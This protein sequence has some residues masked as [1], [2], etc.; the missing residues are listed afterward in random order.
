MSID[1]RP[2]ALEDLATVLE[3][4]QVSLGSPQL[5]ERIE[6]LKTISEFTLRL[7]AFDGQ[8]AVGSTGTYSF[9][10]TVPGERQVQTAGVTMVGVLPTH[11]RRGILRALLRRQLE[12]AHEQGQPLAALFSSEG[13]IY[14]R[15][16]FGMASLSA[17]VDIA[18][19]HTAFENDAPKAIA[20]ARLVDKDAAAAIFPAIWDRVR[21]ATPGMLSRSEAWWRVR[22]VGDPP[23]ARGGHSLLQ[24]VLIEL[25]GRAAAYAIYR[26]LDSGWDSDN[27]PTM[28]VE[29]VEAVGDDSAATAAVWRYLYGIDLVRTI[30]ARLLPIDHPLLFLLADARRLRMHV[31]D[32]LWVR[33]VD[34]HAALSGRGYAAGPPLVFLVQ[35]SLC[36]WN[37]GSWQLQNGVAERTN[38]SPDLSLSIDALSSAY[39][40]AFRFSQLAVAGRVTELR[41]GALLAAD[42]MFLAQQAPWSPE[43]F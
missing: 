27:L 15:F 37:E 13:A 8:Q 43:V 21:S 33:L 3:P 39:L 10:M 38:Q 42:A 36:P 14:R 30:K 7:G 29:V 12:I 2:V 26:L 18:R 11:R 35:D 24:R 4:A 5:P 19:E 25:D 17:E 6:Q 32:G 28:R 41:K 16:G 40:G 9:S 20:S 1:I 31:Y 34:V 22:R 23:W